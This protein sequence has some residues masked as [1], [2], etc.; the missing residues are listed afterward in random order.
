MTEIR[1]ATDDDFERIFALTAQG[2]AVPG[3]SRE[4]MRE[5]FRPDAYRVAG[6]RGSILGCLRIMRFSHF[7]GSR[8]VPAA[9]IAGVAVAA[10]ARGRGIG[11]A[12]M[13]EA[14]RDA[15]AEGLAISSLYPATAPVYRAAGYGFGGVRTRWKV[16]LTAL[17]VDASL[18]VEPFGD[19]ARAEIDAC[20]EAVGAT[21]NGLVRRDADW[22]AKRVWRTTSDL[23][24]Y[25]FLVRED[26]RVTGW[27]DYQ[28][29]SKAGTWRFALNCRDLHWLTPGA[30]RA[31]L[32]VA[33][34]HRSTAETMTWHG[35]ATEPLA[36]LLR[37]DAIRNDQRFR[38]M[39]RLLDVPAAIEA[40]GYPAG[41]EAT[42][43]VAA[44]DPLLPENEGPWLVE[45]SGGRAKVAPAAEAE[46]AGDVA[47]LATLWS[48]LHRARDIVR[49]GGLRGTERALD[50][51]EA[52]FTGPIPWLSDFY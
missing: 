14:L 3:S 50:A 34:L 12:L 40:R 33:A 30:A 15:R 42:V 52:M 37:E 5:D 51:L 17:P 29:E 20:Y 6:D 27:I 38:W 4:R 26:G 31:L 32:G 44:R 45:V 2:F 24:M 39:V 36:D 1:P 7:W 13:R 23:P 18:R 35:P 46:A 25:R 47:S 28:Q 19:D 10:E 16:D 49:T 21:Q 9:G 43:T 22:W 48:G 11:A 41:V 8:A